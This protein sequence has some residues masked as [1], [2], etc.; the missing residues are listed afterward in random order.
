MKHLPIPR[1]DESRFPEE[2]RGVLQLLDGN[3][4][5]NDITAILAQRLPGEFNPHEIINALFAEYVIDN[6]ADPDN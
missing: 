3:R 6:E 1:F 4:S 2:V 5:I